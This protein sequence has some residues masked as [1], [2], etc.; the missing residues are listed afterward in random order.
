ME[1]KF[2]PIGSVVLLKGGEKKVMITGYCSVDRDQINK[3]YDYN[4]CVYP[5]GFLKSDQVC[6]FS[7]DQIETVYFKGYCDQEGENF[8]KWLKN[9][10]ASSYQNIDT[11][12]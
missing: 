11:L 6:L 5:E 8:R 1:E 10:E 4:G 3:V 2:L 9:F 7:H 12:E